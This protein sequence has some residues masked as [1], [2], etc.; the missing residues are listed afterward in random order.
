MFSEYGDVVRWQ[1]F[2]MQRSLSH[3]RLMLQVASY[4]AQLVQPFEANMKRDA[5]LIREFMR[6]NRE[7]SV[8]IDKE[9]KKAYKVSATLE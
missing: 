5:A 1:S 7:S 4:T 3:I 2:C 8:K 6:E 9:V